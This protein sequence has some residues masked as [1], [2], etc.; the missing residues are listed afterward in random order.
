[1]P[2]LS[3]LR[4]VICRLMNHTHTHQLTQYSPLFCFSGM[5]RL[6]LLCCYLLDIFVFHGLAHS[7]AIN[8][9]ALRSGAAA[10]SSSFFNSLSLCYLLFILRTG[11]LLEKNC[12][13]GS[14]GVY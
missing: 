7:L 12:F 10:L 14:S 3:R 1:M 13:K 4:K 5:H 6:C 8:H 9:S 2:D 11:C